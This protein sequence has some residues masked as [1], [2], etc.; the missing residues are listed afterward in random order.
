V[1]AIVGI[2]VAFGVLCY[3]LR[4]EFATALHRV[5]PAGLPWPA[6]AV[7]A[8]IASFLCYAGVQRRLLAA[9]GARLP[10]RTMV[11]LTVAATGLTNLVPGGTAPASGW[12][13]SQYRRHGV[14]LPLAL[15]AVTDLA[16]LLR[17]T[18]PGGRAPVTG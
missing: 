18:R 10:R 3:R 12:L 4:G 7:V 8:E 16:E 9:G 15:W 13:V 1:V 5:S 11:S 17:P 6:A 2:V 14:Q